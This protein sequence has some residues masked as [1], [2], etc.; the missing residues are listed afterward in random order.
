MEN[1]NSVEIDFDE[2][3]ELRINNFI[4]FNSEIWKIY[5]I[6]H[7]LKLF[8]LSSP[9]KPNV[10]VPFDEVMYIPINDEVMEICGF[11]EI[12]N[13]SSPIYYEN[14]AYVQT[15]VEYAFYNK[16]HNIDMV[17]DIVSNYDII[18]GDLLINELEASYTFVWLHQIQNMFYNILGVELIDME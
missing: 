9:E 11:I 8:Y 12:S 15:K 2:L 1:Y 6:D 17:L 7:D 10:G 18:N 16:T 13:D 4:Y 5:D 3:N 14:D